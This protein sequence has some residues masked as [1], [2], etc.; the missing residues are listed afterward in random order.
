MGNGYSEYGIP[1]KVITIASTV[2][3]V[4]GAGIL[5]GSPF[6]PEQGIPKKVRLF[7]ESHGYSEYTIPSR[8]FIYLFIYFFIYFLLNVEQLF[9]RKRVFRVRQ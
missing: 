4:F 2:V 9:Y 8:V 1:S 5:R 7:W 6:Y 3:A